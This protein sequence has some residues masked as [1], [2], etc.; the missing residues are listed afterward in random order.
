[1]LSNESRAFFADC[2]K[3]VQN[4]NAAILLSLL[5]V[6]LKVRTSLFVSPGFSNVSAEAMRTLISGS[7]SKLFSLAL[8]GTAFF[9]IMIVP[10][11]AQYLTT[12]SLSFNLFISSGSLDLS[13]CN[14]YR[15]EQR[16]SLCPPWNWR[17]DWTKVQKDCQYFFINAQ[18][19][20]F[21]KQIIRRQRPV[22]MVLPNL[23]RWKSG[24]ALQ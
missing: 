17:H 4:L 23:S 16:F 22:F 21:A 24:M 19:G 2:F 11:A 7:F 1:M 13:L 5:S 18:K 9:F 8:A 6:L 3:N 20:Q 14:Q 10:V 12:G 15:S